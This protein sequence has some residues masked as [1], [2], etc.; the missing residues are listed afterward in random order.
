MAP[1]LTEREARVLGCLVEKQLTTPEY[2][3]LTLNALT[4]A[5]NQKSN[6]HPVV[7]FEETQ[8]VRA[9]DKLR[10]KGLAEQ[11]RLRD[12]RV[13]KYEHH[14]LKTVGLDWPEAAVMAELML[15][16]PQ[17]AGELR[18]HASRMHPFSGIEEVEETLRALAERP[19]PLVIKLPRQS[20]RKESRFAHLL[21]GMPEVSPEEPALAPEAARLQALSDDERIAAL[22]RE[23]SA[24]RAELDD[25]RAEFASFRKQFD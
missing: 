21:C 7:S 3:P 25:L 10:E 19:E 11:V 15:R 8:V 9:L 4:N 2:Y 14:F 13:P 18:S 12:S 16:G 22:Q 1:S 6:R 5:C 24:L 23:A 17:T 20:G